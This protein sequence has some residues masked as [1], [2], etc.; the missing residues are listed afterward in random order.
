VRMMRGASAQRARPDGGAESGTSQSDAADSETTP[1]VRVTSLDSLRGLACLA[2]LLFHLTQG[3]DDKINFPGYP[4]AFYSFEWA[5][6]SL[7]LFFMISGFVI[8]WSVQSVRTVG[9]FA[10]S[11]FSRLFPAFWASLLMVSAYIL[12]AQHV[13][14]AHHLGPLP[15]TFPQWLANVTMLPH[16]I[17]GGHFEAIEGAY[18]TLAVEMGF[19]LVIGVLMAVGL[20]K[21]NRIVPTMA[22]VWFVDLVSTGLHFLGA[23]SSGNHAEFRDFTNLFLAGMAL[24]LLYADRS[25]P[26]RD[27]QILW[28]IFWSTPFIEVLRF[29]TVRAV[30][31]AILLVLMYFAVFRTV[32]G[33]NTRPFIWL[34]GI[35]YSL[36]LV[37]NSMGM[38]TEKLL[39]DRGWDRNVVVIVAFVQAFVLAILLNKIVEKPVTRWLRRRRAAER[40]PVTETATQ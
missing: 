20:T 29:G 33:L 7:D 17:P 13:V 31:T 36:Y 40:K 15:F 14:G 32:P 5:Q 2:I 6:Y 10:Y 22:V 37:H 34:G 18:W 28:L 16:W 4:H 11:R 3:F 27:R 1:H 19:Y 39:L 26:R 25:R 21:K 35:S 8:L 12:F 9:D 23:M 24:Y 30:A 38:L